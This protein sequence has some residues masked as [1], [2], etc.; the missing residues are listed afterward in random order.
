MLATESLRQMYFPVEEGVGLGKRSHGCE[1]SEST[2]S[3]L[4]IGDA[5]FGWCRDHSSVLL[6][7]LDTQK[8]KIKLG[9]PNLFPDRQ[10]QICSKIYM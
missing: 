10:T 9:P 4:A 2:G 3:T 1:R 6:G 5:S 8:H 7:K